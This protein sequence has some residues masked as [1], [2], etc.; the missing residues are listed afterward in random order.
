[1]ALIHVKTK[2]EFEEKVKLTEGLSIVDFWAPWC[3]PCKMLGPV[4]EAVSNEYPEVTF[5]KVNVDEAQDLAVEFNVMSIPTLVLIRDGEI[6]DQQMGAL[7][8]D[9]LKDFIDSHK[10]E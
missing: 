1:M 6:V 10:E 4:F 3:G 2:E 9:Q 7:S 8:K 5:A